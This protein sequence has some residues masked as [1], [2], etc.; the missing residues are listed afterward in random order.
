MEILKENSLAVCFLA[1]TLSKMWTCNYFQRNG[2]IYYKHK[3][4]AFG[5]FLLRIIEVN[6]IK[7]KHTRILS[8]KNIENEHSISPCW[9]DNSSS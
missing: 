7:I 8:V 2:I 5:I 1:F 9:C 3:I 4:I 6:E